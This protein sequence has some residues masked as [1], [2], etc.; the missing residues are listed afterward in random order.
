[1]LNERQ[2]ESI[3]ERMDKNDI[4][5]LVDEIERI[6][7]IGWIGKTIAYLMFVSLMF[8][9]IALGI[10]ILVTVSKAFIF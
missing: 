5:I 4:P 7:A 8:L 10:G 9:M 2:L 3:L 1:M 6:R